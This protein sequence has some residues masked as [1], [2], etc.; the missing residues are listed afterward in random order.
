MRPYAAWPAGY[1]YN[2][3][4]MVKI[5]GHRLAGVG[6]ERRSLRQ[7]PNSELTNADGQG[8]SCPPE[9]P[10]QPLMALRAF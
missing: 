5:R 9:P 6:L 7:S 3:V 2:L 10:R 4:Y 1:R 8:D